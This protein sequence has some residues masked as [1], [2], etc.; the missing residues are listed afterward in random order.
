MAGSDVQLMVSS[1]TSHTP[2]M[3]TRVATAAGGAVVQRC[4]Q[5]LTLLFLSLFLSFVNTILACRLCCCCACTSSGTS[6][7]LLAATKQ[8]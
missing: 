7:I 8:Q 4:F 2:R 3:H 6:F 1:N 5:K